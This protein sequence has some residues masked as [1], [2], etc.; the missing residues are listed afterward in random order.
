MHKYYGQHLHK[1]KYENFNPF[2]GAL[3]EGFLAC[4]AD[5]Q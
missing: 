4:R 3:F 5:H 1:H 2:T